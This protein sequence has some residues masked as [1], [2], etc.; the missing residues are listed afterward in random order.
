MA[1][2]NR[3]FCCKTVKSVQRSCA[4]NGSENQ[5]TLIP[6]HFGNP[7]LHNKLLAQQHPTWDDIEPARVLFR[8]VQVVTFAQAACP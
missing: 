7:E 2:A 5:K 6:L 3:F 4:Q 1:P 8:S